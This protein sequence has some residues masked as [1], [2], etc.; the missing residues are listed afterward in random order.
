MYT[1]TCVV[2]DVLDVITCTKFQNEM[3]RGYDFIG[4]RIFHFSYWFWMGLTTVQRYCAACDNHQ[5]P[6][7]WGSQARLP[8][9]RPFWINPRWRPSGR[10]KVIEACVRP[11]FGGFAV[12]EIHFSCYYFD[13]ICKDI[14]RVILDQND[15]IWVNIKFTIN[16]QSLRIRYDTIQ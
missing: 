4:G 13:F 1:K 3:F 10:P 5:L 15:A 2:G 14:F 9:C 16:Q 6:I 8:L 12:W 7:S 11:C